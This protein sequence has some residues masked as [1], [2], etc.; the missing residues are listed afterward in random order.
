MP[1]R[2]LILLDDYW[3]PRHTIEPAL[4][5]ILPAEEFDLSIVETVEEAQ[6]LP[7]APD[8]IVN[9]KDGIAN[10]QIPTPNWYSS[11]LAGQIL[12]LV[13]GGAG[14]LGIHCGLANIPDGN[15]VF[16]KVLKGRFLRH[17]PRCQVRFEPKGEHPILQ[18]VEA[19][20]AEDEH[21]MVEVLEAQTQVL[22][23]NTSEHGTTIALWAHALGRG[24]VAGVTPGHST[25]V[26]CH[27]QYAKLLHNAAKW[28]AGLI[29]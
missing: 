27:P 11:A 7:F 20:T 9:F 23:S 21:Y 28:C 26:L 15:A 25:E 16:T 22:G 14:F 19:F 13:E 24:R 12:A 18:G 8:L 29:W 5:L 6:A 2:V 10:T 1:K 4:P 17:P 3:H